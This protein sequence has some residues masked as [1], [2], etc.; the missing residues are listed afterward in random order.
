[1]RTQGWMVRPTCLPNHSPHIAVI[2]LDNIY[3]AAHLIP[4]F[5]PSPISHNIKPHHCYDAFQAFYVNKYADHH[6]FEIAA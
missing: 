4:I 5:G 1:M 3:C 6:T 2:H